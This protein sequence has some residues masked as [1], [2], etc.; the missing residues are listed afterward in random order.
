MPFIG[1]MMIL[2]VLGGIALVGGIEF[3]LMLDFIRRRFKGTSRKS[4]I[5]SKPAIV[6]HVI[7]A[8]GVAC[9]CYGFFIEPYWVE[10]NEFTI[11]TSK[12]E[13]TSFRIVQFSDTHCDMKM[14][15]EEKLVEI[16]NS[17]K[18]DGVNA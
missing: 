6:V 1:K 4:A 14:R 5:R 8:I 2:A 17:L 12:L 11:K 15:N 10:V 9:L 16:V 13:K 18:P 3:C 7:A